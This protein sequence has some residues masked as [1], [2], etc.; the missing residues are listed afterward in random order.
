MSLVLSL[1]V[2]AQRL[3][4]TFHDGVNPHT[5]PG[6]EAVN[7]KLLRA[8]N[9]TGVKAMLFP[10]PL[11]TGFGAGEALLSPWAL[12]CI[13]GWPRTAKEALPLSRRGRER[14]RLH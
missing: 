7:A 13:R 8:L 9:A 5:V 11:H 4:L 12:A 2:R 10:S 6:A 1:D 14:P 3:A